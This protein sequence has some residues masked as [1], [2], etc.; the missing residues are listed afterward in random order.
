MMV[1]SDILAFSTTNS[2]GFGIALIEAM[3]AGLPIVASDV[4][5]CREVLLDGA[6]G[7]L[8]PPGNVTAWAETLQLL[9]NNSNIRDELSA[10]AKAC[11]HNYDIADTAERWYALFR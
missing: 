10:A 9:M 7:Q 5:C 2:E 8:L 6:A 3:A 1:Y 4:P 11:I